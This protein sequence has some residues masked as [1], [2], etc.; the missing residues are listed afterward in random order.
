VTA[1]P[2]EPVAVTANLLR[3]LQAIAAALGTTP[4]GALEALVD[5]AYRAI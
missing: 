3:Q 1:V 2:D 4:Q 5:Q